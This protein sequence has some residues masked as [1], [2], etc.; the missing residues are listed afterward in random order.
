MLADRHSPKR[1]NT[2]GL[3]LPASVQSVRNQARALARNE[4]PALT[5]LA[6]VL[7][8]MA[9]A[10][11]VA[12]D[13]GRFL[14]A[15]RS[16]TQL[17]GYPLAELLRRSVWDITAPSE[18]EHDVESLWRGFLDYRQQHGSYE[19]RRKDGTCVRADYAAI[20]HV[21][22]GLHVSLLRPSR[23]NRAARQRVPRG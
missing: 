1:H 13:T 16:A 11:L 23:R 20:A 8:P 17:T 4:T 14:F 12:D 5:A 21:L 15:N 7:N 3:T 6:R 9:V 10:A 19:V 18:S 22:P 2:R